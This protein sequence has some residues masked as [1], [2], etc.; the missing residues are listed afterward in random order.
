MRSDGLLSQ[1]VQARRRG[2][3]RLGF[4]NTN[5]GTWEQFE[6]VESADADQPWSRTSVALR[7]RRLPQVPTPACS[8]LFYGRYEHTADTAVE[9][10]RK[11][12]T[13]ITQISPSDGRRLLPIW[14]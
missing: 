1:V 9:R 11:S 7:S 5:L 8:Q 12:I 3:Q 2:T 14:W 13:P 4:Y 10:G 6:L